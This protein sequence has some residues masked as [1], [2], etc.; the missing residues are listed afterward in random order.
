[1]KLGRNIVGGTF[2]DLTGPPS[3]S[4]FESSFNHHIHASIIL[5]IIFDLSV[6]VKFPFTGLMIAEIP[7][8]FHRH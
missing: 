1:M 3:F 7:D 6:Q 4:K 2:D 8:D 5:Y